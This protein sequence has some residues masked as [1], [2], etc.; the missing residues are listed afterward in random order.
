MA[1]SRAQGGPRDGR[2]QDPSRRPGALASPGMPVRR[3]ETAAAFA[4]V[5]GRFPTR[6]RATGLWSRAFPSGRGY[7][8]G[9][10]SVSRTVPPRAVRA[11]PRAPRTAAARRAEAP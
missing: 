8:P 3:W 4:R 9:D 5:A 1:L 7:S 2:V 10:A 11:V 6:A